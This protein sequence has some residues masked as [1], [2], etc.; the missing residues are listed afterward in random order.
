MK[1]PLRIF[2]VAAFGLFVWSIG[3]SLPGVAVAGL[4]VIKKD[5]Y[6]EETAARCGTVV[7]ENAGAYVVK[8]THLTGSAPSSGTEQK[9]CDVSHD[10]DQDLS[11]GEAGSFIVPTE[12]NYKLKINILD[13]PKKD[14]NM[15]LVT[16]CKLTWEAK[17]DV[18]SNKLKLKD[19]SGTKEDSD[20]RKCGK[21]NQ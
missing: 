13:G 18:V 20:N 16:G 21:G 15:F 5:S 14:K 6:C 2:G 1:A 8:S 17:G 19:V 11:E 3:A 4:E 9:H 10:I 12:C 7:F